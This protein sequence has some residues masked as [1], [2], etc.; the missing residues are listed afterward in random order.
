MPCLLFQKYDRLE[1]E[2]KG[3]TLTSKQPTSIKILHCLLPILQRMG[4]Y[5][6]YTVNNHG[7]NPDMM[8]KVT[9]GIKSLKEGEAL[10]PI[11]LRE[12]SGVKLNYK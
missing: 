10:M 7:V 5:L 4:A 11:D 9:C 12:R 8:G 1:L 2:V 6:T 3:G